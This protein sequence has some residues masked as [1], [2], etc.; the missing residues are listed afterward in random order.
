MQ[1]LFQPGA[2]KGRTGHYRFVVE[3]A[4]GLLCPP[5]FQVGPEVGCAH[6]VGQTGS[7]PGRAQAGGLRYYLVA[8]ARCARRKGGSLVSHSRCG[9]GQSGRMAGIRAICDMLG[10]PHILPSPSKRRTGP[11]A[12]SSARASDNSISCFQSRK[13][14]AGQSHNAACQSSPPGVERIG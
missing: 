4:S 11:L 10:V 9:Q 13:L 2:G 6:S 3:Q 8:L 14:Q 5:T 12:G 1:Q 7:L